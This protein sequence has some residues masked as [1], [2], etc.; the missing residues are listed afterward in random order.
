VSFVNGSL[1]LGMALAAIPIVL[2]LTMRQQPK[3][4]VFPAIRFLKARRD[5]NKRT[6]QL[7]HWI[8]LLLRCLALACVAL[9]LARPSTASTVFGN[10]LLASAAGSMALL[11]I[12]LT[13]MA[14]VWRRGRMLI[15]TLAGLAVITSLGTLSILVPTLANSPGGLVGDQEAPVAAAIVV[16]TAPRMAYRNANQSRLEAAREFAHWI[17]R[18]LPEGSDIALLDARPA[19]AAFAVDRAAAVKAIDRLETSGAAGPM[20]RRL[21]D[22]IRLVQS[23]GKSRKEIY[24]LTDLASAAWEADARP[25][26][27]LLGDAPDLFLSVIDLGNDDPSNFGVRDLSLSTELLP[28][29]GEL[30]VQAEIAHVGSGG[31]RNVE[32][33]VEEPDATRPIIQD[34]KMLLPNSRVRG[35]QVC[36]FSATGS[37]RVEFRLRGLELGTR[38][39][40]LRIL[41]QDGLEAD[42]VRFFTVEVKP[43]W[44]ILVVAPDGV[45]NSFFMEAVAPAEWQQLGRSLF[46]C[47]PVRQA[48]LGN[49]ILAEFAA[50]VLLDPAPLT[51]SEWRQLEQYAQAGGGLAI[52]LGSRA[53][54]VTSFNETLAQAVIGGR[55]AREWRSTSSDLFLAPERFDHPLLAA[56]RNASAPWNQMPVYRH[57]ILDPVADDSRVVASYSN[58]RPAIVERLLGK[59]RVIVMTT[60]V[61]EP[62]EPIGRTAWN[63][64]F[65]A[66]DAWPTV[67]L[68]DQIARFIVSSGDSKLNYLSGE[69]A[70]I[71]L[72]PE[73]DPDRFQLFGPTGET[74]DVVA[75]DRRLSVR[76]TEIAGQYRLK[77]FRGEPILRGFSVN[78]PAT[79]GDLLRMPRA[80][81]DNVLG[82][83][84]YQ[85]ATSRDEVT[86]GIGESRVGREFYSFLLIGLA[87]FLAIEQLLSNRFYRRQEATVVSQ[88]GLSLASLPEPDAV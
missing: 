33:R 30:I 11:A 6:L 68:L 55:L 41:G 26:T 24:V 12:A 48:E 77:G 74:Q 71:P 9:A 56:F 57:W 5:S 82:A 34:G 88:A 39:A 21:E 54:P 19:P 87:V 66:E 35:Q 40:A 52:F 18:Q 31:S 60:P 29:G 44:P 7:R 23:S 67:V 25:L 53:H 50:V 22:A 28:R 2:H 58:N 79:A 64:L 14:V 27:N 36:E 15:G 83:K 13:I 86:R 70:V 49:T 65:T 76:F 46:E 4:L 43:A 38:H 81:L 63:E 47:R 78:A 10:W 59:G 62:A 61:S 20:T 37:Q 8:L 42:D 80:T 72:S 3:Q 69:T 73:R 45:L 51:P 1:L 84:R 17:A 75:R 85:F 32:L 16:D